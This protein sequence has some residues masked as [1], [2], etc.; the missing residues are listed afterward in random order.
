MIFIYIHD[1]LPELHF[2]TDFREFNDKSY[3]CHNLPAIKLNHSEQLDS[4]GSCSTTTFCS[5]KRLEVL[6]I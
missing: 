4:H 2:K 1:W 5:K 6:N 3:F